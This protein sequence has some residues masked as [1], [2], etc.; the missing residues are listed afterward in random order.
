MP[1]SERKGAVGRGIARQETPRI[2]SNDIDVIDNKNDTC[3]EPR[4][5]RSPSPRQRLSAIQGDLPRIGAGFVTFTSHT[6]STRDRPPSPFRTLLDGLLNLVY[7]EVCLVC[8]TPVSRIQERGVCDDCWA[9]VLDLKIG[10]PR[11]CS[12]GL[13]FRSTA[14]SDGALCG[15]CILHAPSYSGARSYGYYAA[16]LSGVI[17]GFKF[18]GRRN[19]AALLGPLLAEV[20]FETWRR[21]DFDLLVPVPLHPKRRR[22]RGYN[23][24]ELLLSSLAPH[25]RLP[26]CNALARIR[27]TPPQ[28]GLSDAQRQENVSAAFRCRHP[29]RVRG[30]RVL[31]VDDVMTTGATVAGA[32]QA[33][34]AGGAMRVSVLTVARTAEW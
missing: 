8:S 9:K 32:A 22:E 34:L 25:V 20:F 4:F 21:E 11:C 12:C 24:S 28:V 10:P 15:D 31:L 1:G 29:E 27:A 18:G 23:Q 19:L 7:P 13:P 14:T 2:H 30:K 5:A 26:R 17:Q 3:D 16:A 33:L 6:P